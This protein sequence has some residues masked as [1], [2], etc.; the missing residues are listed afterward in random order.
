[1]QEAF[2]HFLWQYQNF[3][4]FQLKTTE[5]QSVKVLKIGFLNS[6]AGPD[7]LDARLLINDI[8]WVGHVEIHLKASDWF[9]HGHQQNPAYQNVILHAV[10]EAD[11]P[12]LH[13]DGSAIPTLLLQPIANLDLINRFENLVQNPNPIACASQ[14]GTIDQI[15][16]LSMLD[17]ALITR[18]EQKAE[19]VH[20]LLATTQNDWEETTYRLLAKNF[21]FKINADTFLKLAERLPLKILQ[22]HRN[23]L[24][25]IEALVFGVAGF[26]EENEQADEYWLGLKNEFAFLKAKYQLT[27]K[28]LGKFE[29]KFLR[30]RPANF[31]TVRLAQFAKLIEQMSSLFSVFINTES[32]KAINQSLKVSQSAYWK[33]HFVFGKATDKVPSMGKSSVEN[34]I[35]NTVVPLLVAYSQSQDNPDFL[36]KA[37]ELLENCPA[38]EN[39][40]TNIWNDLGLKVKNAHDSQALIQQYNMM[41]TPKKCLRCNVGIALL[42]QDE[43]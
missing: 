10:W 14:F 19:L 26:L 40:I 42:R 8:E 36:D 3:T 37:I 34:L 11:K 29:W 12:I 33:D 4:D 30:L 21:G 24:Q 15:H 25:Q 20:Q 7:F 6:N 28:I 23:N 9:V 17:K 39:F 43:R 16:K 31:P 5:G 32:S 18:L 1:M 13:P 2:L 22:K 27:D 35:I 38:E 41:C